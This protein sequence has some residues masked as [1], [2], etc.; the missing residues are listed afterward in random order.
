MT[1]Y[2]KPAV[3]ALESASAAIQNL[4]KRIPV[5]PDSAHTLSS[6]QAYDLDE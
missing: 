3:V 1:N 6:G 2:Q 4:G 5:N